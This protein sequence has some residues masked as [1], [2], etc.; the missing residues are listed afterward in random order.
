MQRRSTGFRIFPARSLVAIAVSA[1]LGTNAAYAQQAGHGE[2]TLGEVI[3]TAT[4]RAESLQDVPVSITAVSGEML[5]VKGITDILSLDK[6]VPGLIMQNSGNDPRPIIRGAGT[7]GTTDVAVPFYIDGVYQPNSGQGLVSFLDLDR[8]EVLKGPQGTLFGRNTLGGLINIVSRK[9]VLR[10]LDYGGAVTGGA[11]SERKIEGFANVPLGE[12]FALRVTAA[13]EK[14]DPFVKNVANPKGGLKDA[15][16]TYGRAQLLWKATDDLSFNLTGTYWHDT[17][18]GNNDY[19]YKVLGIPVNATQAG[20]PVDG[21]TGFLDF[22]QGLRTGWGG[23]KSATGNISNGDTS[24]AILA[25]P[26][27][28]A[29]DYTPHRDIKETSA[30]LNITW[31]LPGH[32][33]V[34]NASQFDYSE[35]RLTDGDLSTKQSYVAGQLTKTKAHQVDINLNSTGSGPLRYTIGAYLFDD[36]SVGSN[37][38]AFLFGYT[39]TSPQRPSWAYWMYQDNGGTKSKALY[40]QADYSLTDKLKVTGGLRYTKDDRSFHYLNVDQNSLDNTFPSY[41]GSPQNISNGS[42]DHND[43]RFGL[44]YKPAKDLM[45]YAYEAT[46]YIAGG[47]QALTNKLLDPQTVRTIEV[48]AKTTALEG[49]LRFNLAAYAAAYSGL[50]TTIFVPVGNTILSQQIPGG[51]I[52]SR[53]VEMDAAFLPMRGL[54]ITLALAADRSTFDKFNAADRL[55]TNGAT[56]VDSHGK[57]W[58]ILDGQPTAFSPDLTANL[59]VSYD[60]SLGAAAGTLTPSIFLKYSDQYKTTSEPYFWSVQPSYTMVDLSLGWRSAGGK[61]TVRGGV[62]NLTNKA[63]MTE[64]TVYSGARA[65]ADFSNPRYWTIRLGYNF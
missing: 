32:Q 64:G 59:G 7:A 48:G 31:N 15:D 13:T 12:N 43:W 40:G 52:R 41:G 39:Y 46:G 55:G 60:I 5:E 27:A 20:H 34:V 23:G 1:A 10:D 53:G 56:Y 35:L 36:S 57:G 62:E 26:W 49:R 11:Y 16:Y 29:W 3:V 47:T 38:S 14:R 45:L 33:L 9:P 6:T 28:V 4:K 24:A 8:V 42:A 58:F 17:S 21:V 61:I 54:E 51:S 25:D 63:V 30:S 37:S 22:R 2:T 65:I 50:T 19:A 44:E 18:N